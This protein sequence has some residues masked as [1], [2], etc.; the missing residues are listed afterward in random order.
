LDLRRRKWQE[1]GEDCIMRS[2]TKY[3]WTGQIKEDETGGKSITD[4]T[5]DKYMYY[6]G[7]TV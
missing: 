6:F 7:W 3:Y 4:G 5:N 2:F 1:A